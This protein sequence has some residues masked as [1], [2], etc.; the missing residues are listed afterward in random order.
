M[1]RSLCSF[2][3]DDGDILVIDEDKLNIF[4]AASQKMELEVAAKNIEL[5]G[6]RSRK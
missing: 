2:P 4:K 1:K 5:K 3:K 6:L